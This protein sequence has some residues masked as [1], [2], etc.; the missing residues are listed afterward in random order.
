[1]KYLVAN[2]KMHKTLAEAK[3][4]FAAAR[5]TLSLTEGVEVIICPS[6]PLIPLAHEAV[7][8]TNIKIGAQNLSAEE[9]GAYTG[10]VSSKQLRGLVDYVLIGHS[11]RKKYFQ[12]TLPEVAKKLDQARFQDLKPIV[13]FERVEELSVI[14]SPEG[15]I[16][17]YEPTFAI[18]SGHPDTPDNAVQ[19]AKSAWEKL[20]AKVP[21]LYGG[22]V[23]ADNVSGFTDRPE[24]S[25]ALVGGASLD[26][27]SFIDLVHAASSR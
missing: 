17:A 6:F 15:L 24:L 26:P 11:E 21:V 20:G 18:G 7:A 16:I 25:G 1:M 2:W 9:E 14:S 27:H 13:C 12:E 8:S 23:T 3:D 5:D 10:E 22:S 4:F 19:V